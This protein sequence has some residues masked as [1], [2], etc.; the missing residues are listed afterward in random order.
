MRKAVLIMVANL[1]VGGQQRMAMMLADALKDEYE[2]F[3]VTFTLHY[4]YGQYDVSNGY[5]I[6]DI[7]IPSKSGILQKGLNIVKRIHLIKK[8]KNQNG[9][10]T[11]IS[12]GESANIINCFSKKRDKT[13]TS[14]RSSTVLEKGVSLIDRIIMKQSSDIVFISHGQCEAYMRQME[15]YRLKAN[16]IYNACD[17][18]DIRKKAAKKI[19]IDFNE[20]SF[21]AVGRLVAEKCFFNLVNAFS[22]II[23]RYPNAEL[24]IIGDGEQKQEIND[25]I[26]LKGL[27]KC[28]TLLG[29]ISN[30][31]K[32]ISKSRALLNSSGR[33][34][35]SNVV[36]EGLACSVPVISTDCKYGPREILSDDISY[37]TLST[38]MQCDYGILTPAFEVGKKNQAE[39]EQIFAN[40]VC[41]LLANHEM[42]K[43][44]RMRS[45]ERCNKF[46][47]RNYKDNWK[48][49][50]DKV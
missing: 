41:C 18:E 8:I 3:F 43:R 23:H 40:A 20:L 48:R 16:V 31:F 49:L 47:V 32:F 22:I 11:A 28:I 29:N 9:I 19:S 24:F 14:F 15:A 4:Q 38:F 27:T 34:S 46:S 2:V 7:D 42:E 37:T 1:E 30:P 45:R 33:E 50:I 21:V 5:R 10:D 12:F 17:V 44:Y 26:E 13:I 39:K 36:L 25:Y 35:F 6:I